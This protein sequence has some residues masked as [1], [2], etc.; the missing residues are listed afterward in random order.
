[1]D[2]VL[3]VCQVYGCGKIWY[4]NIQIAYII[5]GAVLLCTDV[6]V[7]DVW[8][9]YILIL[10]K[11]STRVRDNTYKNRIRHKTTIFILLYYYAN[12]AERLTHFGIVH[13]PEL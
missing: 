4:E 2:G 12:G 1:M 6:Q 7:C 9:I 8:L 3:F 5:I 11:G 10:A 13:N